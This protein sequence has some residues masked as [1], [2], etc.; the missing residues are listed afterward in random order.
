MALTAEKKS[1]IKSF[2]INF[3]IGFVVVVVLQSGLMIT[4]TLDELWQEEGCPY[5]VK[6]EYLASGILTISRVKLEEWGLDIDG[7]PL[8]A[9][10]KIHKLV[11]ERAKKKIPAD[12][13]E[14]V[15][16]W[17]NYELNPIISSDKTIDPNIYLPKMLKALKLVATMDT[18]VKKLNQYNRYGLGL[19]LM[20]FFISREYMHIL[21]HTYAKWLPQVIDYSTVLINKMGNG[22]TLLQGRSS[23]SA[24]F[25]LLSR[26]FIANYSFA[27]IKP[28]IDCSSLEIKNMIRDIDRLF[29]FREKYKKIN[30]LKVQD[31]HYLNAAMQSFKNEFPE[32]R[33]FLYE[34]CGIK[35]NYGK[36]E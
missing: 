9:L 33:L 32:A 28:E 11:Y 5:D 4:K 19:Q 2:V 31:Q 17:Y 20:S 14:W 23:R 13:L 16:F 21:M 34:K 15:Y 1:A 29:E 12:D 8:T 7:I 27:Q 18:K 22:D 30:I 26:D 24:P 36:F 25:E 3:I 35:L 6:Y 10:K